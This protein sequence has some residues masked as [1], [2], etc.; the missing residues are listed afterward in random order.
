MVGKNLFYVRHISY[1]LLPTFNTFQQMAIA[2]GLANIMG[3]NN[4]ETTFMSLNPS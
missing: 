4:F 2:W 1:K 3:K